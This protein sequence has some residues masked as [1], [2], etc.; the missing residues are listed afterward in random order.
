MAYKGWYTLAL[1]LSF[2]NTPRVSAEELESLPAVQ[3]D[4]QF[5]KYSEAVAAK[6]AQISAHQ[7]GT[8]TVRTADKKYLI[9]ANGHGLN[10]ASASL[11]PQSILVQFKFKNTL[12]LSKA[13]INDRGPIPSIK[14]D[15][16]GN[17]QGNVYFEPVNGDQQLEMK[18]QS[19]SAAGTFSLTEKRKVKC[20][21]KKKLTCTAD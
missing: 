3:M 17:G 14:I 11:F 9:E 4:G 15:N 18:N 1:A 6:G 10:A 16:K 19:K 21:G 13:Y 5:Y 2:I 8:Y 7:D 20:E 12:G